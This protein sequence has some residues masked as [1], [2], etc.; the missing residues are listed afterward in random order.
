MSTL[1]RAQRA[2]MVR[3]GVL[4]PRP[5]GRPKGTGQAARDRAARK[6]CGQA[7]AR[8]NIGPAVVA[9][10]LAMLGTGF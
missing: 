3:Q 5:R 1:T 4:L 2:K 7:V 9:D 8:S 10:I 6:E